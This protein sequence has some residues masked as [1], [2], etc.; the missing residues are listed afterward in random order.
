MTEVLVRVTGNVGRASRKRPGARDLVLLEAVRRAGKVR[1]KDLAEHLGLSR[2]A[3][4]QQVQALT[5]AGDLEAETDPGDRRS[6]FLQVSPEG[7]KK[8]AVLNERGH[9]RWTLFTADWD[10]DEIALLADLLLKLESSIAR[11]VR[12]DA[13]ITEKPWRRPEDPSQHSPDPPKG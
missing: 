3:I 6:L 7:E 1:P 9:Q 10:E 5:A 12:G 11:A 2:A 4:T 13:P 8:L